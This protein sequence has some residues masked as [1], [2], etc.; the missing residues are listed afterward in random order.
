ME[1]RYKTYI[2]VEQLGNYVGKEVTLR[3]W[4]YDRTEKGKLPVHQAP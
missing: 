3:G 1:S 4:V 2:Y